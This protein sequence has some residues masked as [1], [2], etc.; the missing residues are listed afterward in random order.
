MTATLKE[1]CW[2]FLPLY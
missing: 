2:S 1:V